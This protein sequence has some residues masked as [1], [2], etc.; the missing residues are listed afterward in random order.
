MILGISAGRA[1]VGRGALAELKGVA[2]ALE[3]DNVEVSPSVDMG[4]WTEPEAMGDEL[5]VGKERSPS[6]LLLLLMVSVLD[7]S[8]L[9]ES[10]LLELDGVAELITLSELA[11]VLL[12]SGVELVRLS[13]L[14]LETEEEL[15]EEEERRGSAGDDAGTSGMPVE[16]WMGNGRTV[17]RKAFVL[18][19]AALADRIPPMLFIPPELELVEAAEELGS[20]PLKALVKCWRRSPRW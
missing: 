12:L 4:V 13:E 19:D 6:E 1:A 8:L 10:S 17:R 7:E 16:M 5:M 11:D 3:S 15:K 2:G 18:T 9:D 20:L 14:E